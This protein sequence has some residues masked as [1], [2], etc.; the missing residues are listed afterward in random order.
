MD[1]LNKNE[2]KCECCG[3]IYEKGWSDEEALEES[4]ALW[5]ELDED[6]LAIVC[7][8]CFKE[9]MKDRLQ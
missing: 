3:K 1:K 2:Y 5:G 8:D 7:D 4:L 6:N 9:F